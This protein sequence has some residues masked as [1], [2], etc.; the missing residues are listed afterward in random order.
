[1]TADVGTS[2]N[3]TPFEFG[4][5]SFEVAAHLAVEVALLEEVTMILFEPSTGRDEDSKAEG[6]N[7]QLHDGNRSCFEKESKTTK[8]RIKKVAKDERWRED[9]S[10]SVW[11]QSKL[12]S[13]C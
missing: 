13:E 5:T 12:Q 4:P 9:W 2:I 1:L 11:I 7:K 6:D 10:W 3:A 8:F